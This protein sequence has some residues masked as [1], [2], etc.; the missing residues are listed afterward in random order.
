QQADQSAG[1]EAEQ[2][3]YYR[4]DYIRLAGYSL[5]L[6]AVSL[7]GRH[8][9]K[10]FW[11]FLEHAVHGEASAL[12]DDIEHLAKADNDWRPFRAWES[13]DAAPG[14]GAGP[15]EAPV[16]KPPPPPPD[17]LDLLPRNQ[18]EFRGELI[19]RVRAGSFPEAIALF[20]DQG[21]Q[22]ALDHKDFLHADREM[23]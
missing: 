8:W 10:D 20:S 16:P 12:G 15:P 23:M 4:R 1:P 18:V 22:R 9:R 21:W 3:A 11:R 14:A 6:F 13:V 2:L 17:F 5:M 7:E 19:R